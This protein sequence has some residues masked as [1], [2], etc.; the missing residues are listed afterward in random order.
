LITGTATNFTGTGT[1]VIP[2]NQIILSG[3]YRLIVRGFSHLRRQYSCYTINQASGT[4]IDLT[5]EN[6]DL[7]AG[8]VNPVYDNYINSLDMSA[9]IN[10]L[11]TGDYKMDLNQDGQ[12]NSL[13][14]S[15]QIYNIFVAG[16]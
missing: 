6:K 16:D 7:L 3:S 14:Y 2:G 9:L 1:V 5:L 15:N 11:F 13:D 8:E 4:Y 10:K 12:V